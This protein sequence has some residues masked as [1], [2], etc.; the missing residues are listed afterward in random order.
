MR[1][2]VSK[3]SSAAESPSATSAAKSY[4][5]C[6]SPSVRLCALSCAAS[7]SRSCSSAVMVSVKRALRSKSASFGKSPDKYK[8]SNR[9]SCPRLSAINLSKTARRS[10]RGA[11]SRS[12]SDWYAI[13]PS[14]SFVGSDKYDFTHSHTRLSTWSARKCF[15]WLHSR[16]EFIPLS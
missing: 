12:C 14:A 13:N 9:S 3:S 16:S 6:I 10:R 4:T 2:L 5:L 8:S 15:L 7:P 11:V 1:R